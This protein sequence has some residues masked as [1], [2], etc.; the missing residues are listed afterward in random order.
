MQ[1]ALSRAARPKRPHLSHASANIN[2]ED[3]QILDDELARRASS[4]GPLASHDE[5]K[6]R[7]SQ[8]EVDPNLGTVRQRDQRNKRAHSGRLNRGE[9]MTRRRLSISPV[10]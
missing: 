6:E 7:D 2:E 3:Q 10:F 1:N 8:R 4:P 5:N 9:V